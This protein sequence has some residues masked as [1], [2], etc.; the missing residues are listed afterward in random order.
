MVNML[1]KL[2]WTCCGNTRSHSNMQCNMA[3][4]TAA[5]NSS[6]YVTAIVLL[7]ASLGVVLAILFFARLYGFV[8]TEVT[9][10][11]VASKSEF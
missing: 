1:P 11:P 2:S 3:F 4:L 9:C 6:T 10:H 8:S 5:T 7:R